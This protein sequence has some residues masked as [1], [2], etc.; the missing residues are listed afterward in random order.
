LQREKIGVKDN[1][2]ELGGHS[3]NAIRIIS[4]VN[5]KTGVRLNLNKVF[6]DPT[7]EALAN[8]ILNN[9]WFHSIEQ[10][11]VQTKTIKIKV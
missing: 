3:I 7:I 4:K 8:E 6:E 11:P 2:F 9:E 5:K 1:F 10:K